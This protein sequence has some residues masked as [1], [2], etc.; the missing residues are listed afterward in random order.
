LRVMTS[1][2][3]APDAEDAAA[4]T[5]G[6]RRTRSCSYF[7][8]IKWMEFTY[9]DVRVTLHDTPADLKLQ[10]AEMTGVPVAS[11][12]LSWCGAILQDNMALYA[13]LQ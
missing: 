7:V 9:N 12:K 4:Q 1:L 5:D 2:G 3:N 6:V 10:L 8:H 13:T 11:Q